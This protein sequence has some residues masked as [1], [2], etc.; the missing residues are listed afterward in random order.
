MILLCFLCYPAYPAAHG[1]DGAS[2]A[3]GQGGGPKPGS[4]PE[5]FVEKLPAPDRLGA[6]GFEGLLQERLSVREFEGEPLDRGQVG[7]LL[8][9]A[10]G[11]TQGRRFVHRT[12][13]SAGGLYPLEFYLIEK[14]GIARYDPFEHALEWIGR[15]D[16]RG[17][18]SAAALGQEFVAEAPAVI[19]IA[20]E[21]ARTTGKY[22]SRGARYVTME[23]GFSCQNLL[24]Q[25]VALDLGAVPIGA[26]VD[27]EVA[28]VVG[29]PAGQKAL[30]LI[31]V[32]KPRS[33][34]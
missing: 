18:L 4:R 28:R 22:G 26:F 2:G 20:A 7:Q 12:V 24:L 3:G 34:R 30:L 1:G 27:E 29:L 19:V 5:R 8:W 25:A 6:R 13:P 10:G 15:E 11:T 23:A 14:D 31:P 32:G 9:A 33:R 21:P 16:R 17:R